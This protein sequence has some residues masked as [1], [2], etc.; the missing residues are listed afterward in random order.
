MLLE[1]EFVK[2]FTSIFT[3]A[4]HQLNNRLEADAE[5]FFGSPDQVLAMNIDGLTE[6]IAS[7][8]YTDPFQIGWVTV[9][10]ALSDLAA[11]G[12]APLGL[13]LYFQIPEDYKSSDLVKICNGAQ[14]ACQQHQ[15]YILGGDTN[16][17]PS[18]STAASAIGLVDKTYQITRKGCQPSDFLYCTNKAG[19]GNAYAFTRFISQT[20][21][22]SYLPEARLQEASLIR[23]FASCC[24]DTSDGLFPALAQLTEV[25]GFGYRLNVAAEDFLHQNAAYV[26]EKFQVPAWML[27]TGPHGDYELVFAVPAALAYEF[28]KAAAEQKWTPVLLGQVWEQE[29]TQFQSEDLTIVVSLADLTNLYAACKNS[30]TLYYESLQNQHLQWKHRQMPHPTI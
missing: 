29:E 5:L 24:I 17:S 18:L 23:K 13:M 15:T 10:A 12:A 25:N 11:V 14:A 21:Q 3:K 1:N 2:G 22:M 20:E 30:P 26:K 28:E 8:L 27:L 16:N 9:V 19:A 4:P 7:G 6:E